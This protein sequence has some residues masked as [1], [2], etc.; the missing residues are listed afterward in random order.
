ML[1]RMAVANATARDL[2]RLEAALVECDLGD[3]G[4]HQVDSPFV[5][6]AAQLAAEALLLEPADLLGHGAALG[7]LLLG[8]AVG[9]P[10]T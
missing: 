5:E 4:I 1:A 2:E 6:S 10:T 8:L 7:A 3:P 9:C